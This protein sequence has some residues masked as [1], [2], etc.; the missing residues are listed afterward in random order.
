MR[1]R[2]RADRERRQIRVDTMR[3]ADLHEEGLELVVEQTRQGAQLA[4]HAMSGAVPA[5]ACKLG[6]TPV[7]SD[8]YVRQDVRLSL[9]ELWRVFPRA[10]VCDVEPSAIVRSVDPLR[11]LRQQM[12][13]YYGPEVD[14]EHYAEAVPDPA[15]KI[16]ARAMSRL[17]GI[18]PVFLQYT[19]ADP[20]LNFAGLALRSSGDR[21]TY[22]N[23][24][25]D[26]PLMGVL[27][28]EALHVMR[29]DQPRLYDDLV[30]HLRPLID[31]KAFA[32]YAR[33]LDAGNRGIDGR[34]MTADQIREE[35]VAD[36]VGDMLMDP[37]IWDAIDDRQLLT[38]L[39]EWLCEFLQGLVEALKRRR[40]AVE[41]CI[42]GRDLLLDLEGARDVVAHT[43]MAWR[44]ANR[45]VAAPGQDLALAFRYMDV[46]PAPA[47]VPGFE[48]SR[49]RNADGTL[50]AV[51]RGE[52][53]PL[54]NHPF[55]ATL[56]PTPPF[57]ASPDVASVYA[58]DPWNTDKDRGPSRVGAYYLDIRNPLQLGSLAEDVVEFG[59][60]RAALTA[61]GAV[62]EA[63]VR[64]AF[65]AID[66]IR[67]FP[68]AE[69]AKPPRDREI[70][71]C[72]P[73]IDQLGDDDY[74]DTYR[75]ADSAR[76][77]ELARRAG[78]DGMQFMGTFTSP[79]LFHRPVVDAIAAGYD[80]Q[81]SM[82]MEYRA[83]DRSQVRSIFDA[84]FEPAFAGVVFK[85]A[86][87]GSPHRFVKP[88]LD[89]IGSG[90][91]GAAYGWGLYL[92]EEPRVGAFY[93][94]LLLRRAQ[95]FRVGG[96]CVSRNE[97]EAA[98]EQEIGPGAGKLARELADLLQAGYAP[99]DLARV[100]QG[101]L[102][103]V[104]PHVEMLS[105]ADVRRQDVLVAHRGG[106]AALTGETSWGLGRASLAMQAA[107]RGGVAVDAAREQALRTLQCDVTR[108]EA[109]RHQAEAIAAALPPGAGNGDIER[110]QLW[111]RDVGFELREARAAIALLSD[112]Q[113]LFFDARP[114]RQEGHLYAAE[115]EDD[116]VLLDWDAPLCDQPAAAAGFTLGDARALVR[117][118]QCAT[119]ERW[120]GNF[121]QLRGHELYAALED[122]HG[123]ARAASEVLMRHGFAGLQYL[124][125]D[126]RYARDP[127]DQTRN[128]VVWDLSAVQ[129]F[130]HEDDWE[131]TPSG[132]QAR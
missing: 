77:V 59:A 119:G 104:L 83:F 44:N 20:R 103:S 122:V 31:E 7:T 42:G 110:A 67:H 51:Y 25:A 2:R 40:P 49:I 132:M 60:L 90:E 39:L 111:V 22:V 28:H 4:L 37:R 99:H 88:S 123:S 87:H 120:E 97:V 17:L 117:A 121:W 108:L 9:D 57:S 54:A 19:G 86:W 53:G 74:V 36:I 26:F 14:V 12:R 32:R 124:D 35:A 84:S 106:R 48:Q 112:S 8:R 3:W 93:R 131:A 55:D 41:G 114:F 10:K 45:S 100:R 63:E 46:E 29:R 50:K 27:G 13:A 98:A 23:V 6:F 64:A 91:G 72:L 70:A 116:A 95:P 34:G 18:E 30:A 1:N 43:L 61:T 79:D 24:E 38:R 105:L 89:Q 16:R 66:G 85:R 47:S 69:L 101:A 107:M 129:E 15:T 52:W 102:E 126:S 76:F 58:M 127:Q 80:D 71:D 56:L 94:D 62:S 118:W 115:L 33:R 96:R 5:F 109:E 92:A 128:Y 81:Y 11:H 82:A 113:A 130:S 65:G 73:G 68:A 75:V 21:R 125:G 78:Y